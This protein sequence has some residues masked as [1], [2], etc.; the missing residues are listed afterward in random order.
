MAI[1]ICIHFLSLNLNLIDTKI[2]PLWRG[3]PVVFRLDMQKAVALSHGFYRLFV[4]WESGL[5]W[6]HFAGFDEVAMQLEALGQIVM[7]VTTR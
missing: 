3:L 1:S 7:Q 6:Q 4:F 2:L 5:L